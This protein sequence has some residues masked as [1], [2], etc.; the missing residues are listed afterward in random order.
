MSTL[1]SYK[2]PA[3]FKDEDKWLK[4]F[5]KRMLAYLSCGA[6][7]AFQCFMFFHG[8]G[9]SVIGLILAILSIMFA[10]VLLLTMPADKYLFGGGKKIDVLLYRII[11]KRFFKKHR[12][13]YVKNYSRESL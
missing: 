11:R 2:T 7:I 3:P 8:L 6:F 12:V 10:G 13:I 9:L 5:T 4:F 1:G